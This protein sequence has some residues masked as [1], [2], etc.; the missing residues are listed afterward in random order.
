M[1]KNFEIP[2]YIQHLSIPFNGLDNVDIQL[3]RKL[4]T[5][6][7]AWNNLTKQPFV[8]NTPNLTSL[9]INNNLI[10]ELNISSN[11]Q[12]RYV[13]ASNNPT[14]QTCHLPHTETLTELNLSDNPQIN[15][16]EL[17]CCPKLK[18]LN[19][20][21]TSI[22]ELDISQNT[23]LEDL[24]L[25]GNNIKIYMTNTQKSNEK[26]KLA[27]QSVDNI[28]IVIKDSQLEIKNKNIVKK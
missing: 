24:K 15:H 8:S 12:L 5:L 16:I 19:L 27:L 22:K 28:N 1:K 20:K 17:S 14:L 4:L 21:N 25:T 11:N 3:C 7:V 10:A 9:S 2:E 6:D 23:V 13:N 18:S 26:I